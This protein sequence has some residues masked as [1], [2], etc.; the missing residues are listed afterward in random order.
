MAINGVFFDV[1]FVIQVFSSICFFFIWK[2]T[3]LLHY[4]SY[5]NIIS[6]WTDCADCYGET[7]QSESCLR[8]DVKPV[9][10]PFHFQ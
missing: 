7:F 1:W 5:N 8:M 3:I 2:E 6:S 9:S 10:P 4:S